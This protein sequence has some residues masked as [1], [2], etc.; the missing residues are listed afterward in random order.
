MRLI[1]VKEELE[2]WGTAHGRRPRIVLY[3][4][5]EMKSEVLAIAQSAQLLWV[6]VEQGKAPEGYPSLTMAE[7][8]GLSHAAYDFVILAAEGEGR[9][10]IGKQRLEMAGIDYRKILWLQTGRYC[11]KNIAILVSRRRDIP[12]VAV[13][14]P[15]YL[16]VRCGAYYDTPG[17]HIFR[18][19]NTGDNISRYQPYFSEFT[20]QY[21][22]WKN[23]KADYY[24]LCHYRRYLSFADEIFP[25]NERTFVKEQL[26]DTGA[27]E[28]Y[29]L[30]D[31]GRM[32]EVIEGNDAVLNVPGRVERIPIEGKYYQTVWELWAAHDGI[33][34]KKE[35]LKILLE[36]IEKYEAE[37]LPSAKLYL[38]GN[39]HR[40]YNC[41]VL[42]QELFEELC[43]FQE[44]ILKEL[45]V[46]FLNSGT[47]KHYP[48]ICAYMGE[49]LYGIYCYKLISDGKWKIEE[50]QMVEFDDTELKE[51]GW[52]GSAL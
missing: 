28:K 31:C 45:F 35:S 52:G 4:L 42:K 26:L 9:A 32:R 5:K 48:R 37:Y 50:R 47:I 22:G 10:V 17:G 44:H 40:G 43:R 7:L 3:A 46:V 38:Y 15:L 19:D 34:I 51:Y 12:S 25:V 30:L 24:G 23:L 16:P 13:P 20:V 6:C 2:S 36:A 14:N 11:K 33:F 29:G 1:S 21:W 39:M 8:S 49:I 18:G 27:M 41:Y